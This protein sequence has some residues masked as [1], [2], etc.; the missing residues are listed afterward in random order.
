MQSNASG[1][2]QGHDP[3]WEDST[4]WGVTEIKRTQSPSSQSPKQNRAAM[5]RP[6]AGQARQ[7]LMSSASM[8]VNTRTQDRAR[9]IEKGTR[10]ALG[11]CVLLLES[12]ERKA[13]MSK[14]D[15]KTVWRPETFQVYWSHRADGGE[16]SGI[17]R[18]GPRRRQGNIV[19]LCS[20]N[21]G[22]G[23]VAWNGFWPVSG[24]SLQCMA[25][26]D[27]EILCTALAYPQYEWA[28]CTV[29]PKLKSVYWCTWRGYNTE[30]FGGVVSC[31][32]TWLF[33][34]MKIETLCLNDECG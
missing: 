34:V 33:I 6:V 7:G 28:N 14:W 29:G 1:V 32:L 26:K 22:L 21:C 17:K 2:I 10:T 13:Q 3:K 18:I 5:R 25:R 16:A 19:Q 31:C 11:S 12:V 23:C 20:L 8:V 30:L 24:E 15:P 27:T 4:Y 9:G